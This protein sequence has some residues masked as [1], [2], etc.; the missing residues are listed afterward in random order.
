MEFIRDFPDPSLSWVYHY[1]WIECAGLNPF[2]VNSL[3]NGAYCTL[4]VGVWPHKL[5]VNY[6]RVEN[7][8]ASITNATTEKRTFIWFMLRYA[9][10][11]QNTLIMVVCIYKSFNPLNIQS[12]IHEK[13]QC[14][15]RT[16]CDI[17]VVHLLPFEL[18]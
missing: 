8:D 7:A 18:K 15:S 12:K 3:E 4:F 1:E 2:H 16:Q 17:T 13:C 9:V 6:F 11:T 14:S 10:W 5:Q